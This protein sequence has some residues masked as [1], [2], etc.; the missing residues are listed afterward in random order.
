MKIKIGIVEDQVI[1]ADTLI[2]TLEELGY[3]TSEPCMTYKQAIEMIEEETPDLVLLDIQLIGKKSGIDVAATINKDYNI[4]FIFLT[5]NADVSTVDLAKKQNP[6]AYLVKP[7]TKDDLFTAIEIALANFEKAGNNRITG[8][9]KKE[10]IFL[11]KK[12][13]Y[14]SVK[15][16]DILYVKSD[17]AYVEIHTS[18]DRF[19]QRMTLDTFIDKIDNTDFVR[20]HRRYVVNS[21]KIKAIGA[22]TVLLIDEQEIPLSKSYK[23]ELIQNSNF[24]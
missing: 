22:S 7:F 3:E 21:K 13:M 5:S 18:E 23:M 10:T 4:P 14:Y 11:K 24:L 9:P 17:A 15:I 8:S 6:H 19:I 1:I 12:E 16:E 2:D 20:T